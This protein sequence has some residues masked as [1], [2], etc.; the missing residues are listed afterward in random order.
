MYHPIR[1]VLPY[2]N[3]SSFSFVK[4]EPY[5]LGVPLYRLKPNQRLYGEYSGP[6]SLVTFLER[7]QGRAPQRSEERGS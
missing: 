6:Y 7:G 4:L 2:T 3:Y 1:S 5:L